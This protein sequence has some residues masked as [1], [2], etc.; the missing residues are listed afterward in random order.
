M[1]ET[2]RTADASGEGAPIL[3]RPEEIQIAPARPF[4]CETMSF[5]AAE[6]RVVPALGKEP[7]AAAP[8]DTAENQST[9]ATTRPEPIWI[10]S[11]NFEKRFMR[12]VFY[13][14]EKRDVAGAGRESPVV[15]GSGFCD[16]RRFV[17]RTVAHG[18][19][20]RSS[21]LGNGVRTAS[22]RIDVP[23]RNRERSYCIPGII[24]YE[25]ADASSILLTECGTRRVDALSMVP[26]ANEFPTEIQS[27]ASADARG[28][29]TSGSFGP[30]GRA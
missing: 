18:W 4:T 3:T 28:Y 15:P 27:R 23:G 20:G 8:Y 24:V 11:T 22:V 6:D 29:G 7:H 30:T 17:V 14:I 13:A 25:I 26:S 5:H 1:L 19:V 16:G 12:L 9:V 2:S 21:A 10:P